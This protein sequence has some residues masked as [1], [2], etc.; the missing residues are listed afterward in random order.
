VWLTL[1]WMVG[2][3]LFTRDN[4]FP[5]FY[6]TDEP[7][8]VAQVQ[9]GKRN[10]HH[11]LLMLETAAR[12]AKWMGVEK[13]GHKIAVVGRGCSAFFSAVATAGVAWLAW[14]YGGRLAGVCAAV[15]M[16][17]HEDVYILSHYFKED[18]ALT[19]GVVLTFVSLVF[20]W[21]SGSRWALVSLGV[22]AGLAISGKYVGLAAAVFVLPV[23][24]LRR[25]ADG[26]SVRRGGG[27]A[28]IFFCALLGTVFVVNL[29]ALR[30]PQ[31]LEASLR[32]ESEGVFVGNHGVKKELPHSGFVQRLMRRSWP[33]TGGFM[34]LALGAL[35]RERRRRELPEYLV[36]GWPFFL[37]LLL[38]FSAKDSGR[39]FLPAIP[40]MIWLAAMGVTEAYRWASE[41]HG[42]AGPVGFWTPE[43]VAQAAFLLLMIEAGSGFIPVYLGFHR[44][45]RKELAEWCASNLPE[46]AV[47]LQGFK[48]FLPD[49]NAEFQIEKGAVLPQKVVTVSCAGD[50]GTLGELRKK[51]VTH[52]A[53][54][55]DEYGKYLRTDQTFRRNVEARFEKR[56]EFYRE[57]FSHGQL[58]WEHPPSKVGTHNPPIRLYALPLEQGSF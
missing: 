22:S 38:S 55:E 19:M 15:M 25:S 3:S 42:K 13:E 8:K 2:M 21:R 52:V 9:S 24:W 39:Y 34:V 10:L 11:P 18:P 45:A 36:A 14:F 44:H 40:C 35:W 17:T 50:A 57:L 33:L 37:T 49:P 56:R 16:L 46:T 28:A 26:S 30:A 41:R 5:Y 4:D 47:I 58:V 23:L 20:W 32:K 29:P 31:V 48:V 6:H 53:L 54:T 51:G 12:V 1:L 43:R 27:R 7:S